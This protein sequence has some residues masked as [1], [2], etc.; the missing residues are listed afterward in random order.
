MNHESV[1]RPWGH[2]T[3]SFPGTPLLQLKKSLSNF[4]EGSQHYDLP[5]FPFTAASKKHNS[6]KHTEW[7]N[8]LAGCRSHLVIQNTRTLHN[9]TSMSSTE[10]SFPRA[11]G[12]SSTPQVAW[13]WLPA[14]SPILQ[15]H[16]GSLGGFPLPQPAC[17]G[18]SRWSHQLFNLDLTYTLMGPCDW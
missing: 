2:L 5:T 11:V 17:L 1:L 18:V 15:C 14:F 6:Y 13:K 7:C 16:W 8:K 10:W 9:L 4:L 3:C 12:P